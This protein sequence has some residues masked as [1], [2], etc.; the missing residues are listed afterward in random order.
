MCQS[1]NPID[2]LTRFSFL[3]GQYQTI[4]ENKVTLQRNIPEKLSSQR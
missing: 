4:G 1:A 2:A 3:K